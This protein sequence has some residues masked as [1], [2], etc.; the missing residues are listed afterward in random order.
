MHVTSGPDSVHKRRVAPWPFATAPLRRGSG[1]ESRLAGPC[2]QKR[3]PLPHVWQGAWCNPL[4][5][6]SRARACAWAATR[7]VAPGVVV[8]GIVF[9]VRIL[10]QCWVV[11]LLV[12]VQI[13][14]PKAAAAPITQHVHCTNASTHVPSL[15]PSFLR[16]PSVVQQ[17]EV[18]KMGSAWHAC[19]ARR[20]RWV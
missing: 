18:V 17:L 10:L 8:L 6:A 2:P 7:D 16:E 12:L 15:S 11:L 13:K 20:S 1:A 5:P 14:P 9:R 19:S 4:T 3:H